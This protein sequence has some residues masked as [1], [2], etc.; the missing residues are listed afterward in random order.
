MSCVDMWPLPHKSLASPFEVRVHSHP[1][2]SLGAVAERAGHRS[3]RMD[4]W[5]SKVFEVS[6]WGPSLGPL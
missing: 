2:R 1:L 3:A 6:C 4:P 5:D